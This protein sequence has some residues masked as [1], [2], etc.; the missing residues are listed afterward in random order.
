[1]VRKEG[2]LWEKLLFHGLW[3]LSRFP[4]PT[5][6]C[7]VF[8]PTPTSIS[9]DRLWRWKLHVSFQSVASLASLNQLSRPCRFRLL[10]D[11]LEGP[12][13]PIISDSR[14]KIFHNKLKQYA[15][16]SLLIARRAA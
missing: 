2:L 3:K 12:V 14:G 16:Y 1:M 11:V 15:T 7:G 13:S 10:L 9:A 4:D 8:S 5:N 6:S